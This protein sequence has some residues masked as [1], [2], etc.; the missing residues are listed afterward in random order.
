MMHRD[1]GQAKSTGGM[2]ALLP[3]RDFTESL[4]ID[5]GEPVKDLHLT[6]AY[7]GK[8]VS[9]LKVKDEVVQAISAIA[10]TI[11]AVSA[12][13]F[14]HATFNPDGG[15]DGTMD[16]CSVYLISDSTILAPL[17][18]MV[19]DRCK[20][21]ID[22]PNQH[23]PF[24][25]HITAAYTICQLTFTGEVIFDRLSLHWAGDEIDFPLTESGV[26]RALRTLRA[27][28]S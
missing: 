4:A 21:L 7:L 23:N 12:R 8:D 24:I 17:R 9:G 6:L 26:D 16:P 18:E 20:K 10:D 22:L 14:A 15:P 3:R 2:V 19:Q 25:P 13:V 5:D 1:A 27:L 11:H 28:R